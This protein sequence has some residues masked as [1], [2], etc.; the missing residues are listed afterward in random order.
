M[1]NGIEGTPSH[2]C[3][4]NDGGSIALSSYK[5]KSAVVLFFYPKAATPGCTKEACA[6]RDVYDRFTKAGA[7]VYGISSG[8]W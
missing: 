3:R 6:F 8:G 7:K 4:T 1:S 5:D 2:T